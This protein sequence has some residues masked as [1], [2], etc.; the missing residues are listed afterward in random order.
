MRPIILTMSAFG[1][2][3][4]KTVID[5]N[6]LGKNGLYLITGDTGAGKT[7][8]FDGITYALF[9]SPSGENRESNMLRSKYANDSVKTFAELKF[10]YRDK[11]Y[12]VKRNPA[13]ERKSLRGSGTTTQAAGAE[14]TLPDG[15]VITQ[16][17]R[18]DAEI[19]EILGITREQFSRIAMIAQ[20]D[21][22]KLLLADTMERQKIFRKIFNTDIYVKFQDKVKQ[23]L[24]QV[25]KERDRVKTGID[26]YIQG[27]QGNGNE[28]LEKDL[29][30]AREN[31]IP[32]DEIFQLI[33]NLLKE[34]EEKLE[35][36]K[37][38]VGNL[39]E[40][41]GQINGKL[42]KIKERETKEK[43][44]NSVAKLLKELTEKQK[45]LDEQLEQKKDNDSKIVEIN[46]EIA[47]L[48]KEYDNYDVFDQLVLDKEKLDKDIKIKS[49]NLKNENNNSEKL[50]NE[51]QELKDR[52]GDLS[53]AGENLLS[54]QHD[55]EI[56]KGSKKEF[57]NYKDYLKE[58]RDCEDDYEKKK[59]S[60]IKAQEYSDKLRKEAEEK[61]RLFN[62]EQAGILA[63][64]LVEGEPCPVCGSK[65]HPHKAVLTEG[66][67]SK[68]Q[69]EKAEE[70]SQV[71]ITSA[72]EKSIK[73][74]KLK[75]QKEAMEADL[76][77]KRAELLEKYGGN[78]EEF[79]ETIKSRIK[80]IE[81]RIISAERMI[82]SEETK[83]TEKENLEKTIPNK[84]SILGEK[85]KLCTKLNE[86]IISLDKENEN[87]DGKINE[88]RQN[89]NFESGAQLKEY[90]VKL[91]KQATSLKTE[92]DNLRKLLEKVTG[93][94][95]LL[96]GKKE[97]IET[98][99]GKLEV[100]DG[101]GLNDQLIELTS[102]QKIL[103]RQGKEIFARHNNNEQVL[104]SIKGKSDELIKLDETWKWVS[105]ISNTANGNISGKERVMIETYV[106]MTYFDR[107]LRR[108][109]MHFMK[110][111][112]GQYDLV[113][114]K[115]S[116]NHRSQTGLELD[117]IDHYN[118]SVRSVKS[119][120]G[121]ESFIASLS[122]ALGLSEEIQDSAGGIKLD[123]MFVD[124][125]FGSLDEET[126]EQAMKALYG[127]AE[128]NRTI[129]I[130]SHVAELRREIDSQIVVTKEKTGSHVEIVT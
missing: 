77:K 121:G 90:V 20:G 101:E 19:E 100:I 95:N 88:L 6:K 22:L 39:S 125:G 44:L 12:T 96:S 130:I 1:P 110:M 106:Q 37:T 71:A 33:S 98:D 115:E 64:T 15:K 72:N 67:P 28:C 46:K 89:L 120:S 21:F 52:L 23:K 14:L 32:M 127:L 61:R 10:E 109:N 27:I 56:L 129:G 81:D 82:S 108:A 48:E 97:T 94:I 70:E 5:F 13:Y 76:S 54:L 69:V 17:R 83:V 24:S 73:A 114:K 93:E 16:T 11:E 36:N 60:Y 128:E 7:T 18:V 75:G 29:S 53:K 43:D 117:V 84:E 79:D 74:G 65:E 112:G 86:E 49:K 87:I 66:A 126:L 42:D 26:Q 111:S 34:D 38:A 57:K 59:E 91:N 123:T 9:G 41:I 116:D 63:E 104:G 107:I 99:L 45:E 124:E 4:G 62:N 31:K 58:F 50:K 85:D 118:G 103:E 92:L 8:I 47:L 105:A 80:D 25:N 119:L 55:Y 3:A 30:L 40:S 78:E 2:Y 35:E 68:K 102:K 51:I 122:L 113:R